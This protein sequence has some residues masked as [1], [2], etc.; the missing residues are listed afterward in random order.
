MKA[1]DPHIDGSV[2]DSPAICGHPERIPGPRQDR[3]L[4]ELRR[5]QNEAVSLM[6]HNRHYVHQSRKVI[7]DT[8]RIPR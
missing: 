4:R 5:P 7:N 6:P 8:A 3:Q 1:L 2:S